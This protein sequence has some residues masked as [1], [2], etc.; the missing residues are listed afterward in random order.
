MPEG[1]D[2]FGHPDPQA[3]VSAGKS[4]VC[5]YLSN[6]TRPLID[7]YLAHG[8]GVVLIAETDGKESLYGAGRGQALAASAL[9]QANAL[10]AP[11][12]V[13]IYIAE[14][15]FDAQTSQLSR[16]IDFYRG[17]RTVLGARS[18]G[19]GGERATVAVLN[20]FPGMYWMQTYGWSGGKWDPRAQIEQY[21]NAQTLSGVRVDLD[22][23]VTPDIGA[24]ILGADMPLT[25]DDV[26]KIWNEPIHF[27]SGDKSALTVLG[28]LENKV[29][30]LA[31]VVAALPPSTGG[32]DIPALVAAIKAAKL[33]LG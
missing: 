12:N 15:D 3:A 23:S 33:T 18:G 7:A 17:V 6:L 24:W 28:E 8:L 30:A 22:R 20:A 32:V 9:A 21:L 10:G 5:G 1:V 14:V 4:F 31:G 16:I 25:A 29:T 26:N 11:D 2:A 13:G 19:Y 27:S